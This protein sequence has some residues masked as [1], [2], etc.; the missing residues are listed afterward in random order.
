MRRFIQ[1]TFILVLL[2]GCTTKPTLTKIEVVRVEIP[3]ELTEPIVNKLSKAHSNKEVIANF[4]QTIN[5]L[6]QCNARLK[7]IRSIDK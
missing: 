7:A 3:K 5:A 6:K 1:S 2:C 4:L